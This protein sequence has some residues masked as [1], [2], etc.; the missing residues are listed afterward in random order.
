MRI[1]YFI[2]DVK[3]KHL[4]K[5]EALQLPQR[6]H[7]MVLTCGN[8]MKRSGTLAALHNFEITAKR[9]KDRWDE[10]SYEAGWKSSP[11]LFYFFFGSEEAEE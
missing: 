1:H 5:A 7:R 11:G 3:E 4:N 10:L 2:F 6:S 9:F 8:N